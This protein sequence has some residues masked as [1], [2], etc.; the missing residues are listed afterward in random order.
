LNETL[1]QFF[2]TL[3]N[4]FKEDRISRHIIFSTQ[5]NVKAINDTKHFIEPLEDGSVVPH[6]SGKGRAAQYAM[7]LLKDISDLSIT[8]LTVPFS[9][10][11]FLA[12]TI[13]LPNEARN[14]WTMNA[15]FGDAAIDMFSVSDLQY[16]V[17]AIFQNKILYE[18]FNVRLSAERITMDEVAS[19]F[20]ELFGKDI[21]YNPLTFDEM[22]ELDIPGAQVFSQMCQYLVNPSS[23]N[24]I[25]VTETIMSPRKPQL[26]KDWLVTHSDHEAFERV[27]LSCDDDTD[28]ISC[29]TIFD[30]TCM[31]GMSVIQALLKSTKG[32]YTIRAAASNLTD[33]R[34]QALHLLDPSRITL[35]H[36]DMDDYSSCLNAVS[37]A[38]GVFLVT[39]FDNVTTDI[40]LE[41]RHTR[42]VIDACQE[43]HSVK[44][45][46][47][48]TFENIEDLRHELQA[49]TT[50]SPDFDLK[51]RVVAYARSKMIS[52]TYLLVPIYSEEIF[53][54][55]MPDIFIDSSTGEERR[56]F[57]LPQ[58]EESTRI[59]C[60][61]GED[62]GAAVVRIFQS[63]ELYAGHEI[64]LISDIISINEAQE[65]IE[66]IFFTEN[67]ESKGEGGK[68]ERKV[69]VKDDWIKSKSHVKDLGQIFQYLSKSD[70]VK[71]RRALAKTMELIPDARPLKRWLEQNR[72]N[73]AFRSMLGLR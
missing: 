59:S 46:V 40:T 16:V 57:S 43:S 19:I 38:D 60:L 26:F 25:D 7:N 50:I 63:Y 68:L 33:L 54:M 69:M 1:W 53:K 31:Q 56:M 41:E 47:L 35:I 8:L 48:S 73:V 13:P 14:Q 27:G 58:G 12:S 28:K 15:C 2:D 45:L 23:H 71:H 39:S 70:V 72:E 34:A 3:V 55:T 4:V 22:R 52:C 17:P 24:D 6:F 65:I 18:G 29:I 49:D 30:A 37:G 36:V 66:E 62:L 11:N 21:I 67:D 9:H 61:N 51:V 44:H 20:S 32:N 10:S 64:A 42:N 5:D